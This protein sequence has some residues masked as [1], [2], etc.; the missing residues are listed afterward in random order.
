MVANRLYRVEANTGRRREIG[1]TNI[2]WINITVM[3]LIHVTIGEQTV[4]EERKKNKFRKSK[5]LIAR[6]GE[7]GTPVASQQC[8]ILLVLY[9]VSSEKH[10]HYVVFLETLRNV[11][12][13]TRYCTYLNSSVMFSSDPPRVF[14]GGPPLCCDTC[15][16]MLAG[17]PADAMTYVNDSRGL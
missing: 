5:E 17:P 12:L 9:T 1:G 16:M 3:I 2:D 4:G 11:H 13:V 10:R 6:K 14:I 15:V 7:A 8:P